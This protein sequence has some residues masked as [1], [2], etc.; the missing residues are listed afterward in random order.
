MKISNATEV[1][2]GKRLGHQELDKTR[3]YLVCSSLRRRPSSAS[4]VNAFRARDVVI[5]I[6]SCPLQSNPSMLMRTT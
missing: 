1:D 2:K 4:R 3:A 6:A 5:G